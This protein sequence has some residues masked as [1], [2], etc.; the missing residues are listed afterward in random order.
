MDENLKTYIDKYNSL[1]FSFIPLTPPK[2][3]YLDGKRPAVDKWAT[4]MTRKPTTLEQDVWF[5]NDDPHNIGVV[6]GEV[7]NIAVID[8]DDEESYRKICAVEDKFLNGTLICKT[9]K[10]YHIYF[11]PD[12]SSRTVTFTL[13]DKTHHLKLNGGYVVAPPSVHLTGKTY[14]FITAIE[15][16]HWKLDDVIDSIQKAGGIFSVMA[17]RGEDRPVNWASELCTKVTTGARNT[18]AAQLCGLLIR[19]FAY[20]PELISGLMMAWNDFYCDPP[21]DQWE[22]RNLIDGEYRRYGPRSE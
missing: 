3:G 7:S 8:L 11:V 15:P 20:D 4:Y 13:G 16:A 9:G 2:G 14:E 21:L 19:K 1:G 17:Q 6:T 18:V 10:G 22:L 5:N 12:K